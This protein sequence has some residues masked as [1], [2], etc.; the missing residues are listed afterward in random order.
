M[1]YC[2]ICTKLTIDDVSNTDFRF[3]PTLKSLKQGADNN[4]PLCALCF[5]RLQDENEPQVISDLLDGKRPSQSREGTWYHSIWLHGEYVP[6]EHNTG[7]RRGESSGGGVWISVGRF[8]AGFNDMEETN[9]SGFQVTARLSWYALNRTSAALSYP[10]RCI[11]ADPDAN[12]HISL[13]RSHFEECRKFHKLC[14]VQRSK[15]M[16]TRVIAVGD[17]SRPP[18]LLVTE[19]L[20]EPYLALSYCWGPSQTT[21]KL[22]KGTFDKMIKGINE[23]RL[24]KTHQEAINFTRALGLQYIWID[25]LCIIQGDEN[26]WSFE[27]RRMEQVYGNAALTIVAARS[28]DACLGFINPPSSTGKIGKACA[29]PLSPS[30]KDVLYLDVPRTVKR[31]PVWTR[32]WC[33]QEKI[34]SNRSVIFCETQLLYEC[35]TWE[36]WEDGK[37]KHLGSVPTFLAP[38]FVSSAKNREADIAKTL[39][40]W[41]QSLYDFTQRKLSNPHDVFAAIASIAKLAKEVLQS[42]YLAGLWEADLVRGLLWKSMHSFLGKRCEP[43]TRPKPTAFAPAP[44]LRAPSWSWASVEGHIRNETDARRVK[45]LFA[46]ESIKVRPGAGNN[47]TIDTTCDVEVLKMP[48]C[49]LRLIGQVAKAVVSKVAVRDYISAVKREPKQWKASMPNGKLLISADKNTS[50]LN[51][52][53]QV[54][55]VGFFD[56]MEE[57]CDEVW[58]LLMIEEEGLM[59]ARHGTTWKRVGWFGVEDKGW[60]AGRAAVDITLG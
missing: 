19:G 34:L 6:V 30:N 54:V 8:R 14:A 24:T 58:C 28:S 11:G 1:P 17:T 16:P 29:I 5:T 46:A 25:A 33:F 50:K 4:C 3:H 45:T 53:G 2:R 23:G 43:V 52:Q 7:S 15:A 60:F 12:T 41:Y 55:A 31:G 35:R 47:W 44:V 40:M 37:S 32:G 26:D 57:A 20:E 10:E 51:L 36:I 59:L 48:S 39:S 56:V 9:I 21:F 13:A 27:S 42:R 22:T 38:G 18:R 49:E